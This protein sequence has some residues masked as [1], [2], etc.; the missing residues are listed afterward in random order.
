MLPSTNVRKM[1]RRSN[2]ASSSVDVPEHGLCERGLGYTSPPTTAEQHTFGAAGHCAARGP[3]YA[4]RLRC[5][6]VGG[7][8]HWAVRSYQGGSWGSAH[9][10]PIGPLTAATIGP[11]AQNLRP[12]AENRLPVSQS[13][14]RADRCWL[15][16]MVR[17]PQAGRCGSMRANWATESARRRCNCRHHRR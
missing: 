6:N 4:L 12:R 16:S 7:A 3:E 8:A 14:R 10:P 11:L 5:T 17:N 2:T 15:A 13:G 1:T 9:S